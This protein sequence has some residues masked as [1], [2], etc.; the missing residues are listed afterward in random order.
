MPAIRAPIAMAA[1]CGGAAAEDRLQYLQVLAVD[2]A[3]TAFD[4]AW[5]GVADD[6]GHL[7]R[8]VAQTLRGA[9]LREASVS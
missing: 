5:S 3:M 1:E 7:Q 4:E 6:I 9:D 8:G 2:P